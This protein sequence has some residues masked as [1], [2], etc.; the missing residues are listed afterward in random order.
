MINAYMFYSNKNEYEH[1]P[2]NVI[3]IESPFRSLIQYKE[4]SKIMLPNSLK[5]N[6]VNLDM[7]DL[8]G[9][10]IKFED[11]YWLKKSGNP[12][13]LQTIIEKLTVNYPGL[14]FCPILDKKN[15]VHIEV[16]KDKNL[17]EDIHF[18]A[19][20]P[21]TPIIISTLYSHNSP[22][23]LDWEVC[24]NLEDSVIKYYNSYKQLI[25]L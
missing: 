11:S 23:Q 10:K 2:W 7:V 8:K 24:G 16:Y 17:V 20:F 12:Q 1:I 15:E 18:P 25:K 19:K 4:S 22:S 21:L 6:M 3:D 5:A 13:K 9:K 14:D